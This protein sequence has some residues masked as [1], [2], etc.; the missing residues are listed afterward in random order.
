MHFRSIRLQLNFWTRNNKYSKARVNFFKLDIKLDD[1]FSKTM[2][3][4]FNL[5]T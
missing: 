5:M 1:H 3:S 4:L 2:E